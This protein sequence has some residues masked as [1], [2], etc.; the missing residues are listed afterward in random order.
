VSGRDDEDF[1][2]AMRDVLPLGEAPHRG[3]RRRSPAPTGAVV[4]PVFIAASEGG[5]VWVRRESLSEETLAELR[6]GR[7]APANRLDLHGMSAE[8]ARPR[9]FRFVRQSRA[10]GLACVALVHGRGLRSPAGAVLK[11]EVPRWLTQLPLSL[12]VEAFAS[13]PPGQGGDGVL[14]VRLAL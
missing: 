7:P 13:A 10:S 3:F 1:E 14:L 6:L 2:R 4:A 12:D 11:G 5:S 8:A 9:V